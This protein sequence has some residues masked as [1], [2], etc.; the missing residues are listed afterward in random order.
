MLP[1]AIACSCD[2]FGVL[3]DEVIVGHC[4]FVVGVGVI[5]ELGTDVG[6]DGGG[7]GGI[8]PREDDAACVGR[9]DGVWNVI[10]INGE[11]CCCC[12][13]CFKF[14]LWLPLPFGLLIPFVL[15]LLL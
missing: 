13:C 12:C 3:E 14:R 4:V 10:A 7:S 15:L 6:A 1:S 11:A 2:G 9:F 8:C 5:I